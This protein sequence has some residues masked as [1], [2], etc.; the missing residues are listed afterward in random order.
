MDVERHVGDDGHDERAGRGETIG[1]AGRE[2]AAEE[3]R[4]GDPALQQPVA[5]PDEVQPA[6]LPAPQAARTGVEPPVEL[7]EGLDVDHAAPGALHAR[8]ASRAWNSPAGR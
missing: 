8:H 4:T 1:V 5:V 6:H 7:G 2:G 3:H